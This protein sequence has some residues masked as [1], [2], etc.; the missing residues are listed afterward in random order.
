MLDRRRQD[1]PAQTGEPQ[2][3]HAHRHQQRRHATN[4]RRRDQEERKL[5]VLA[6]RVFLKDAASALAL[7]ASSGAVSVGALDAQQVPNSSGAA[8]AKRKARAGACDCHHHIY[9]VFRFP[10]PP[11]ASSKPVPDARLEEFRMLQRRIGT[12]RNIVV[13]PSAYVTDNRVTL[14]AIARLGANSRGGAVI[15]PP[16]T[17]AE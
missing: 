17:D 14:D 13:T 9:D 15:P 16:I 4:T 3:R 5:T 10:P 6:R 12:S 2:P 1:L 11:A 8:P 7:A